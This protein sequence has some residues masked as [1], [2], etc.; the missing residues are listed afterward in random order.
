[1]KLFSLQANLGDSKSL[2]VDPFV[3]T[4]PE[5]TLDELAAAGIHDGAIRLSI[6][7]EE[8]ADLIADLRQALDRAYGP[9]ED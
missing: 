5:L 8:P 9:V 2:A 3:V 1:M 4:H 7:L 6:G